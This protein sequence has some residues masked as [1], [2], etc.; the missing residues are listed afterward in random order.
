MIGTTKPLTLVALAA[1][2]VLLL[3]TTT[4]TSA[5]AVRRARQCGPGDNVC[6]FLIDRNA[7]H[8]QVIVEGS[9]D[10]KWLGMA[11]GTSMAQG[12]AYLGYANPRGGAPVVARRKLVGAMNPETE[13]VQWAAVSPPFGVFAPTKKFVVQFT[14]PKTGVDLAKPVN[15]LFA[16]STTPPQ[17][18]GAR[19]VIPVHSVRGKLVLDPN[20]P[21]QQKALDDALKATGEKA[22]AFS[23][24]PTPTPTPAAA[25]PGDAGAAG[26]SG[27]VIGEGAG[28]P[29]PATTAAPAPP[30][31]GTGITQA[32]G[33]SAAA[34]S[35]GRSVAL[36]AAAAAV[37][38]AMW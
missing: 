38:A 29:A 16:G 24:N 28:A 31:A 23:A 33:T 17:G 7:T 8:M 10:L 21:A 26:G 9:A 32:G 13:A 12:D 35:S 5:Q 27:M 14:R 19:A 4:S 18:D 36:A 22:R 30:A 25:A 11:F 37:V 6:V 2:V 1:L 15:V 3:A 20:S 34:S